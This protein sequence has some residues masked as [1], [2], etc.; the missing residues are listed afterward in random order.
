MG[1]EKDNYTNSARHSTPHKSLID[2]LFTSTQKKVLGLLF[3]S[4]D[5]SFFTTEVIQLTGGS[6]GVIQR[7]LQ[8][9]V[10]KVLSDNI[11]VLLGEIDALLNLRDFCEGLNPKK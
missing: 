10:T 5:R 11:I 1:I 8:S 7:E 4:P 6:S 2:S 3:A 9:F